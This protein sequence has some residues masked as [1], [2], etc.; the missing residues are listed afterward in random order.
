MRSF[1]T[2]RKKMC[3]IR[4]APKREEPDEAKKRGKKGAGVGY[5]MQAQA[6]RVL[7]ARALP[8]RVTRVCSTHR[9]CAARRGPPGRASLSTRQPA[10]G[11]RHPADQARLGPPLPP[12]L[13]S[14]TSRVAG[15]SA[16]GS[17]RQPSRWHGEIPRPTARDRPRFRLVPLSLLTKK[18]LKLEHD[19]QR[20]R[21]RSAHHDLLAGWQAL[22][23]RYV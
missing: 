18:S 21:V 23:S 15:P 7:S 9:M 6:A 16:A 20:R 5:R 19:E 3:W 10:P 22:S 17:A 4:G 13:G 14:V 8:L 1:S 2:D 12:A 11:T